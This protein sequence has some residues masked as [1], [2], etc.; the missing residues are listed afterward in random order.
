MKKALLAIALT[1]LS[2]TAA[3]E[4]VMVATNSVGGEIVLTGRNDERCPGGFFRAFATEPGT[5][6]EDGNTATW[7]VHW[8][9]WFA[10]KSAVYFQWD[11]NQTSY[12][13]KSKFRQQDRINLPEDGPTVPKVIN[14]KDL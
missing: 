3:A 9:C 4:P 11:E 14:P 1:T 5:M 7:I 8:G 12:V 6:G 10:N 13:D 2:M